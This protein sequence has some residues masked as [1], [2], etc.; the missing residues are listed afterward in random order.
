MLGRHAAS[1]PVRLDDISSRVIAGSH[2]VT[3]HRDGAELAIKAASMVD[4]GLVSAS[5]VESDTGLFTAVRGVALDTLKCWAMLDGA[6]H[7]ARAV[8][9]YANGSNVAM[10]SIIGEIFDPMWYLSSER[11]DRNATMES[12]FGLTPR[13]DRAHSTRRMCVTAAWRAESEA[14]E[15]FFTRTY[16]RAVR[17]GVPAPV[18]ERRVGRYFLKCVVAAWRDAVTGSTREPFFDR[19]VLFD[20]AANEAVNAKH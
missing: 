13:W 16:M 14:P 11:P 7:P 4:R 8:Y 6:D 15:N 9:A 3:R 2:I 10:T 20:A 18:A 5:Y 17:S 1:R 12:R 19:S